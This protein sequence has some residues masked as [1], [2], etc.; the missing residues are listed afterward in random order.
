LTVSDS[1]SP[2]EMKSLLFQFLF[3]EEE[4]IKR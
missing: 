1:M 4:W 2:Q 3:K